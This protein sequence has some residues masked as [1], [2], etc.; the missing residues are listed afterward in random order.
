VEAQQP[1]RPPKEVTPGR[2]DGPDALRDPLVR[3]LLGARLI[4]NLATLNPDGTVH[5]VAMWFLWD[6]D[7]VLFPTNHA[8]RKA[9]NSARDGRATVMI[10]DS[11]GGLDLRGVTIVGSVDVLDGGSARELNRRIH[12][13]YLTEQ[14][15][16]LDPVRRYLET[17]DVTLRLRPERLS[18]WDLRTTDQGRALAESGELRP[19]EDRDAGA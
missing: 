18:A 3:E 12:L 6:G 8:T 16:G 7:A 1:Y 15:L 5:L 2:S 14:G 11:R 17:D 13:K 9:R 4:A 19:L 10:D